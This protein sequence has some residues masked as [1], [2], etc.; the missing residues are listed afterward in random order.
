MRLKLFMGAALA[1]LAIATAVQ[2]QEA[3]GPVTS[4]EDV[5]VT[6]RPVLRNRTDDTAPTLSYDRE[7]FQRFE[8][9]TVGDALKRVPSVTFLSDVLESDGARLRGLEPGYTK[10]LIDGEEVPGANLD[11]SFFV[12]RIPAEL[13]ERVEVVRSSSANRSGDAVAGTI[14]IVLRD[15]LSLD[16]GYVR[17]GAI[18]FPDSDYGQFGGTY[19]AVW[20]GEALGGR[21]LL[22]ANV[23]DRRNPKDKYSIRFDEPGGTIDNTEVQTDVRDG[24]D[25]AFNAAYEA[26]VAGGEFEIAGVFIRT[27]RYQ[28]EDSIEY[29]GGIENDANLLTINDNDLDIRTDNLSLRTRYEREMFGGET[30]FKLAYANID[31]QQYEFE[32]ESEYLRDAIAFPDEDRFTLDST[33][34]DIQDEEWKA[35]IEHE[36]DL[37]NGM[38]LEFGLQGNWKTRDALITETPRIRFNVPNAPTPRPAV[39]AFGASSPVA[40]GDVS[41]EET[42]L[43]PYVMLS[44]ENGALTW[45]AGLRYETTETTITDRT[46]APADQVSE[47]DEAELLPSFSLRYA[48]SDTDRITFSAARTVRRPSFNRLSPALLEEEFGDSDF[49]GNPDL[50]SEIATG[51]DLGFERRLGRRGVAG[52]NVF[53]RDIQ[54]LVEETNTGLEGSGGPGTFIYTVDNVGDGKVYGIEFDLSTPLDFIGMEST[55]V[56]LNYSWLDSEITDFI[57]ERRFN[58]QSDYVFSAGFTQDL[59]TW[60]AA[61]GATYRKQGDAFD[62]VLAEEVTTSYGADLEIFVE[63]QFGE[64][65]IVRLTGSNL[66]DSSKDETFDKFENVGDQMSRDYDEY[67]VETEEAGPVYQLVMRVA[68]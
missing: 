31:D 17:L 22:G 57:G 51:F 62:R 58:G 34:V 39:P 3:E 45:E 46:V 49:V 28:D 41:I 56:F 52:I 53:Y 27:D 59:P 23:Q 8:P 50:K 5:I 9:L 47:S 1:P 33:T 2:A 44:G 30:T 29:R 42:R 32:A 20:G 14:N 64:N 19:G 66:L 68:F 63:K 67:E 4:V 36:L 43:D 38:E 26:D 48:V 13:I 54:D 10:I 16:G 15:A 37:S 61:F 21:V 35:G 7:Y 24:T 25:Y 11:R 60:G 55:G 18:M 65:V 40:G 12:D 6:G